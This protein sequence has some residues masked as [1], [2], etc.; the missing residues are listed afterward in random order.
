MTYSQ[1]LD[2]SGSVSQLGQSRGL[3]M[4]PSTT[5]LAEQWGDLTDLTRAM[6]MIGAEERYV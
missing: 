2:G 6:S 4:S 5:F 1:S 3:G